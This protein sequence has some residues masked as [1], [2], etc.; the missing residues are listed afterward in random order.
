MAA[1]CP[2]TT[3]PRFRLL[4][5]GNDLDFI[6]ALKKALTEADYQLV[7]CAH[8]EHAI[9]FLKSEIPYNL[10]L[11]DFEWRGTEGLEL[12]QLARSHDLRAEPVRR[13]PAQA[14][15]RRMVERLS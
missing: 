13:Q 3:E 7:S 6:A 4:Y 10:L 1:R 9:M 15:G 11:I 2:H 12:A 8:R 5:Q 14:A